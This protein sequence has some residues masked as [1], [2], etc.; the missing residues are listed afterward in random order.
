VLLPAE[1]TAPMSKL[2]H[3]L[4]ALATT[5][6]LV[7]RS[8]GFELLPVSVSRVMS[9]SMEPMHTEMGADVAFAAMVRLFT[10]ETVGGVSK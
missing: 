10:G 8:D 6:P 2:V 1:A 9:G 5:M 7:G 3:G 4:L